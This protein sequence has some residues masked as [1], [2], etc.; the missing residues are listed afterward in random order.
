MPKLRSKYYRV[1][2]ICGAPTAWDY[3][4]G[5]CPGECYCGSCAEASQLEGDG[6]L[7]DDPCAEDDEDED[8]EEEES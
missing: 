3:D 4:A 2:A 7:F 5:A 6:G 1:C 8:E